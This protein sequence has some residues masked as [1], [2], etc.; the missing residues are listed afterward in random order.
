M[1]LA[2]RQNSLVNEDVFVQHVRNPHRGHLPPLHLMNLHAFQDAMDCWNLHLC[3]HGRLMC[4]RT[5]PQGSRIW[6]ISVRLI[7]WL[8]FFLGDLDFRCVFDLLGHLAPL[9]RTLGCFPCIV[10]LKILAASPPPGPLWAGHVCLPLVQ[11]FAAGF[12]PE[13]CCSW[14][15]VYTT[16]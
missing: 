10:I 6:G 2:V 8:T 11:R 12:C 7:T 13:T 16:C 4:P 14:Y 3:H 5:V 9:V 15:C 1:D